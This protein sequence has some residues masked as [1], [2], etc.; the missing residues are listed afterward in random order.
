MDIWWD[1]DGC[2]THSG[3]ALLGPFMTEQDA[4]EAAV[5][6]GDLLRIAAWLAEDTD[7]DEAQGAAS[8]LLA[9]ARVLE[10]QAGG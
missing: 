3:P 10:T 7:N 2:W 1:D 4:E 5:A 8:D 9:A 6:H